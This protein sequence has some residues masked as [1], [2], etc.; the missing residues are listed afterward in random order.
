VDNNCVLHYRTVQGHSSSVDNSGLQPVVGDDILTVTR[1]H[2]VVLVKLK[3]KFRLKSKQSFI[4][5][6]VFWDV[7]QR[8]SRKNRHFAGT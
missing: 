8:G 4:K 5:K 3:K 6:R 7:T 2:F 1:N